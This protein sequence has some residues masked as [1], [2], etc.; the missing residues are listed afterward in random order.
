MCLYVDCHPLTAISADMEFPLVA[1][2]KYTKW[3][4][5]GFWSIVKFGIRTAQ[6]V[7]KLWSLHHFQKD[8]S[9]IFQSSHVCRVADKDQRGHSESFLRCIFLCVFVYTSACGD[10]KT[11]LPVVPSI[12][13]TLLFVWDGVLYDLILASQEKMDNHPA[14]VICLPPPLQCW[15][16]DWWPAFFFFFSFLQCSFWD[17]DSDLHACKTSPLLM[18]PVHQPHFSIFS[19]WELIFY[20]H[21]LV[22]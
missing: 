22:H 15:G 19:S 12:R 14:L 3:K 11:P 9:G 20:H 13:S 5:R 16:D 7:V 6:A 18:E 2:C 10:Q 21:H 1:S 17:S 4:K 8:H